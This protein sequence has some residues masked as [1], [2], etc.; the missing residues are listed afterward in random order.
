MASDSLTNLTYV[1][2]LSPIKLSADNYLVWRNHMTILVGLHQ[3]SHH[4]D[5]SS[6][7]PSETI[8]SEDKDIP[9]P[10]YLPWLQNDRK[11]SLLLLLLLL[12]ALTKEAAAK[13]LGLTN[14]RQIWC[15]LEAAYSNASVERVQ[16]LRVFDN[17]PKVHLLLRFSHVV[18]NLF[19]NSLR[20]L[21]IMLPTLINFIGFYAD[22]VP[23]MRYSLQPY[24]PRNRLHCFVILSL[25]QRA[26]NSFFSQFMVLLLLLLRCMLSNSVNLQ[27]LAGVVV[28]SVE[29]LLADLMAG[30]VAPRV[31]LLT[32]SFAVPT[33]LMPL[34]V[35]ICTPL[36]VKLHPLMSP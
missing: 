10:K 14:A 13:V 23:P 33:V 6:S 25:R 22:L 31:A 18:L 15:A 11:A 4:I 29:I 21:A 28:L 2:H 30:V 20:L 1:P 16:S 34:P 24:G 35:Q 19:V 32:V 3:L 36:L 27:R 12:S 7:S 8:K 17:C 26:M 9:N 5:G